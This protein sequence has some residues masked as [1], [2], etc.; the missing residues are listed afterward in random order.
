MKNRKYFSALNDGATLK[1]SEMPGA[2]ENKSGG[3]PLG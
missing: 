2:D 1:H 3:K